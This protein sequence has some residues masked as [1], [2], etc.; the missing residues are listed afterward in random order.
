[1]KGRHMGIQ[2][3]NSVITDVPK[4]ITPRG[5]DALQIKLDTAASF[6]RNL[7]FDLWHPKTAQLIESALKGLFSEDPT[8]HIVSNKFPVDHPH[9]VIAISTLGKLP[10]WSFHVVA[11]TNN[12]HHILIYCWQFEPI[13]A[14]HSRF[15]ENEK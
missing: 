13:D 15:S 11:T 1:M 2:H 7:Y 5:Y 4:I 8:V 6:T 14:L 10:R 3:F 9:P 12:D